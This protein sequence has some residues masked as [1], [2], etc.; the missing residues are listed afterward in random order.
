M[1]FGRLEFTVNA[2]D[3]DRLMDALNTRIHPEIGG[4]QCHYYYTFA[5]EIPWSPAF[6]EAE[7][8]DPVLSY[9]NAVKVNLARSQVEIWYTTIVEATTVRT[10][11]RV[12][13]P[14]CSSLPRLIAECRSSTSKH[15]MVPGRLAA[16]QPPGSTVACCT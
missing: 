6:A 5:G 14:S 2:A 16:Q 11:G 9:R 1:V 7:G 4:C 8:D 10:T 3:M 13:V 12:L 15:R